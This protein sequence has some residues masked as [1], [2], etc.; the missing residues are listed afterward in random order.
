LLFELR[1]LE[2]LESLLHHAGR[3]EQALGLEGLLGSQPGSGG[4]NEALDLRSG[5][6]AAFLGAVAGGHRRALGFVY[7]A[8]LAGWSYLVAWGACEGLRVNGAQ[9][10]GA[11]VG[12]LV[13]L[14]VIWNLG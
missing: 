2:I 8:A 11:S 4:P 14:A 9:Q 12:A 1:N 6:R 10:A 5:R 3:L 7:G 13:G